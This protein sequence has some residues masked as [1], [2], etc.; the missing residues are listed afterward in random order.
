MWRARAG[1]R[2]FAAL[3]GAAACQPP[4]SALVGGA[5]GGAAGATAGGAASGVSG[6]D[7]GAAGAAAGAVV[8]RAPDDGGAAAVGA[9][10]APAWT[11]T[12]ACPDGHEPA[13]PIDYGRCAVAQALAEAG[14]T[15]PVS[16]VT[17][18]SPEAA[19]VL[20]GAAP[21]LDGRAESYAILP[22]AGTTWVVGRDAVGAMYGA[23]EL[24][25][26]LRLDGRA[27]VPPASALR[28]APAVSIRAA[29]LFF[30]LPDAGETSSS[31]WFLDEGFWRDYLDLLAHARID[32]LDVHGMYD[33]G[34]TAFPNALPYLARSPTFPNVGVPPADR[35]RNLAMLG[36]VIAMARARGIRVA[37][38]SY[39]A[40]TSL[41]GI[42]PEA[43]TEDE[44][45]TYD[46]EAAAD[47]AARARGLAMLG[48]RIG[49][50]GKPATWY[51]DSFVAGVKSA[52]TGVLPYTR[53][54]VSSKP[55][56]LALAAAVGPGMVLEAKLNG[57]HLASPYA[58]AGGTMSK[59]SS[60]SYQTYLNPPAPWTFVF[61]VRAGGTHRIFREASFERTRRAV[62]ALGISPAVAGFSL[63][64]PHAFTPQRDFY[65]A[66][67]GDRLSPWAFARDD[68][69]YLLWG[70]LGYDLATPEAT[71]RKLAAREAG[72]DTL[73]PALQAASDIVPWIQ[74]GHTCGPDSRDFAPELELGGDVAQWAGV[75]AR[76]LRAC[77][78]PG[79][80]DTFAF[81]SPADAAADLTLGRATPR[82][83]PVDVA[84][85]VLD[86]AAAVDAALAAADVDA[87]ARGAVAR[88]LVRE[89]R[90]LADLGRYFGHKLR[91]ATALAVYTRT[92][93]A[94]WLEAARAET[95]TADDAWRA[96][97]ADTAYI[98]PFREHLRMLVLGVEP[99]HWTAEVPGLA[100]DGDAL[101]AVAAKVAAAPPVFTGVLPNPA[102]WLAETRAPGPG[103]AELSV[104]PASGTAPSP[105][106]WTVR[107]RFSSALPS[108][109]TVAV[110]AKPFDSETD[111][112]PV[113]AT[114]AADGTFTAAVPSA[115]P[116]GL[117][118][119][120]V[121]TPSGAWRYPDPLVATPYV[122]VAP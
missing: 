34:S 82:V 33:L 22:V 109:A 10:A 25:E 4:P 13:D 102:A 41:T 28:G 50:T 77:G 44:L 66:R 87:D 17:A 2:L 96:L 52:G 115:G 74:T 75:P 89:C 117:F 48:F 40:S 104:A 49:E 45:S 88:D 121:R 30:T 101:D 106:G 54:W 64:P 71:F 7:G 107:V 119:V 59:L 67:P 1:V 19:P 9:T 37:L 18:T 32:L 23:L 42:G 100:A 51:I 16:I 73:W 62:G 27:A 105:P 81:A 69:M 86:E 3:C 91:A 110:L 94:E 57:E 116:G 78:R 24:A 47:V 68:L 43:L 61:Q 29:N 120:E 80:F 111:F 114:A 93:V 38:M 65:H 8:G 14:A 108:G 90:A 11:W 83:S 36:R 21:L 98:K 92:G 39:L 122:S 95:A 84:A 103:L 31:W 113:P 85:I 72:T 12:V 5:A 63:E 112:A 99:F 20:A 118:A 6:A 53:S 58:I 97:A 76:P 46:R 55:D 56:I 15:A 70:R 60:Y 26:R 35:D 79:P